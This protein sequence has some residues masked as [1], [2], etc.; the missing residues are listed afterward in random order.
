MEHQSRMDKLHSELEISFLAL[1][2][3]HYSPTY[4][5]ALS[6]PFSSSSPYSLSHTCSLPSFFILMP[7][8]S[9]LFSQLKSSSLVQPL[10]RDT[11]PEPRSGE[12]WERRERDREEYNRGDLSPNTDEEISEMVSCKIRFVISAYCCT[13]ASLFLVLSH[14]CHWSI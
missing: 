11:H 1:S 12:R 8:G 3:L 14:S 6:T 4:M 7:Q 2:V 5:F 10:E 9:L 13:E